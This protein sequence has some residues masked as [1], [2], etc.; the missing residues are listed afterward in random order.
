MNTQVIDVC[1]VLSGAQQT[2][3]IA[4]ACADSFATY[5]HTPSDMFL[6]LKVNINAYFISAWDRNWVFCSSDF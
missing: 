3:L 5:P 4:V 2:F 6:H 1:P